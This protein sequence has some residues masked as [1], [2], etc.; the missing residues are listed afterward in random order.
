MDRTAAIAQ[1]QAA[2]A[3][4]SK[5][6]MRINPAVSALGDKEVQDEL[7]KT[8]YELTKHIEVVKKRVGRLKSGQD[9]PLT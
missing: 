2:C 6:M 3:N 1:I 8:I 5:E 7:Y 4:I 9:T